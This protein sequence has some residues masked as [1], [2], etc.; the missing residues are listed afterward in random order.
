MKEEIVRTCKHC[1]LS[2]QN[3]YTTAGKYTYSVETNYCSKSCASKAR[4]CIGSIQVDRGR[5]TLLT[6]AKNVI[7]SNGRYT[8]ADEI[9]KGIKCSSR[10]LTKHRISIVRINSELGYSRKS[11]A[12]EERVGEILSDN[13]KVV[14]RQ[15]TFDGLNGRTGHDL[16]VDFFIP[17]INT[18][19]EADGDQHANPNHPWHKFK[20]GTVSEYDG[21]K[22]DYF[23]RNNI[24]LVRVAYKERLK[25]KDVLDFFK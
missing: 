5:D 25:D 13:F 18:V 20:N 23:E 12:F 19:V 16:R 17:E 8:T 3:V 6:Q 21:I 7:E 9:C 24:A 14:E 1:G 22:N 4:G 10:S 15:K 11:S 2:Y